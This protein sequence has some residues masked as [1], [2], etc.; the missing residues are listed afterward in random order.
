MVAPNTLRY[1]QVTV[2]QQDLRVL[3]TKGLA[4]LALGLSNE[5]F[6]EFAH[7]QEVSFIYHY[8]IY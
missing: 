5:L 3:V 4:H 2:S 7:F 1:R 8:Y 6:L